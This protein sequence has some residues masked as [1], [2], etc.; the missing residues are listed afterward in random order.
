MTRFA[1]LASAPIVIFSA[2][3]GG[4]VVRPAGYVAV[5]SHPAPD[6]YAEVY[7][8]TPPPAPMADY[9]SYPPGPGYVWVD[10]YWDWSGYD[11]YWTQGYWAPGRPN[12]YYVRP[13]YVV[14]DGRPIYRRGYWYGHDGRRD[15][16]Y[17]RPAAPQRTY[18]GH[19]GGGWR[20][21]PPSTP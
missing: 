7:V 9:R 11:W 14:V 20:G 10:G 13:S 19:S 5:S 4:C 18:Q 16:H 12:Y 21:G 15:Y 8:N 2:L 3:L 1:R 17:A 6:P